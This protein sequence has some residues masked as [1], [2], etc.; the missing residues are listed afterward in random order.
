VLAPALKDA[1]SVRM[2]VG[3]EIADRVGPVWGFDQDGVMRNSGVAPHR[4]GCG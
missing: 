4:T 2:L 3:D 1:E